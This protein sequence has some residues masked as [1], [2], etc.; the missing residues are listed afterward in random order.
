[1]ITIDVAKKEDAKGIR[2]WKCRT[3]KN[4]NLI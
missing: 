1:M 2:D 4:M 3:N